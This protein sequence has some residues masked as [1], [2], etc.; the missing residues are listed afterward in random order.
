MLPIR[1]ILHAT[2]FSENSAFAFRVAASL[3]RDHGARLLLLHVVEEPVIPYGGVMTPPPPSTAAADAKEQLL[4]I[5]PR[6]PRVK[7]EHLLLI[8]EP[9]TAICQ[10]ARDHNCDVIVM[11]THGRT[12]LGRVLMGSVAEQVVRKA[13]CPVLT[14]KTPDRQ[15]VPVQAWFKAR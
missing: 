2:D 8:G 11:G 9:A 13:S 12:G 10:A 7:M 15:T 4:R 1:T 14:M 6:D 3:A 5:K